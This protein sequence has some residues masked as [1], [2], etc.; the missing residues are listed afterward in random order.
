[1]EMSIRTFS[2]RKGRDEREKRN[3]KQSENFDKEVEVPL[4][5]LEEEIKE[6]PTERHTLACAPSLA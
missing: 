2:D 1:M 3:V 4:F 5:I 6:Q